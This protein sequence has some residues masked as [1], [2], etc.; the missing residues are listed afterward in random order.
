MRQ[1][2]NSKKV[3]KYSWGSEKRMLEKAFLGLTGRSIKVLDIEPE[4]KGQIGYT[5]ADGTIHLAEECDITKEMSEV[6]KISFRRGVFAHEALHQI[7]TDFEARMRYVNRHKSYERQIFA[8]LTNVVE[9]P[10]IENFA[11]EVMGGTMYKSLRFMIATVYKA[12]K[13]ITECKSAF[14]QYFMA[15]IQFGD[16][17]LIKGGFTFPEAKKIFAL[18]APIM[19]QAIETPV[20]KDRLDLAEEM[21]KLSKPLWKELAE[22]QR[23]ME[24][25]QKQL[26][27]MGKSAMQGSG[28]G[29]S[30][31]GSGSGDSKISKRRKVTIKK[32]TKEEFEEMKK[33]GEGQEGSSESLPDEIITCDD[34]SASGSSSDSGSSI[35]SGNS[36]NSTNSKS[37]KN[38]G[39]KK[40]DVEF[41]VEESDAYKKAKEKK[42]AEKKSASENSEKNGNKVDEKTESGEKSSSDSNGEESGNDA[43]E[44]SKN[45]EGSADK[46]GKK[47]DE[48]STDASSEKKSSDKGNEKSKDN[49]DSNETDN[50]SD[51]ESNSDSKNNP[52]YRASTNGESEKIGNQKTPEGFEGSSEPNVVDVIGEEEYVLSDEEIARIES[53][54]DKAEENYAKEKAEENRAPAIKDFP[55]T[56]PKLGKRTCLNYRVGYRSKDALTLEHSY[57]N[58]IK[59][60]NG[61]IKVLTTQLRRIFENDYEE[62][63]YRN[64]GRINTKRLYSGRMTARVF[65]RRVSPVNKSNFAVE[66]LVDESGSM[67]SAGKDKAAREATIALVEVFN[68]LNIPCYVIGFTADT[69]GYDVVHNHYITWKNT[70]NERLKLLNICARANNLDGYSI[71]YATEILKHNRAENKLLIVLSDGQPAAHS[72][73]DGVADTKLAIKNAKKYSNVLGIAIGNSDTETIHY[74]YEKDFIHISNVKDLFSGLSRAMQELLKNLG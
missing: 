49:S 70:K 25:F 10:A 46:N 68:N 59:S 12:S 20:C 48:N 14:A 24:E 54:M 37:S 58:V 44:T 65:D 32:V 55:V 43:S 3:K 18:T 74:M 72:Y 51:S 4:M 39:S 26:E 57:S 31:S 2:S 19:A 73:Y 28:K 47:S 29:K 56:S 64:S 42:S 71:R 40:E 6:E 62:T 13:P 35:P 11:P 34:A 7:F 50:D 60:F 53:E 17:G 41:V 8:D 67:C 45:S 27:E 22:N 5:S 15:L 69:Q 9:D 63:E 30:A 66:I 16:M 33:N 21:F 23:L 61:G 1:N 38:K 52:F 36:K